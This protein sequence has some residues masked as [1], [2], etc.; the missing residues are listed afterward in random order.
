MYNLKCDE[1]FRKNEA[2]IKGI[3]ENFFTPAKKFLNVED[4]KAII[5]KADFNLNENKVIIW[6]AE[7]LMTRIDT[8]SDL[9]VM[10]QM[11]YVEL[12]CFISRIAHEIYKGSK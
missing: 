6:Y 11:R 2:P 8:L 1:I 5:K 4:C 10:Q 12:L 3:M 9:S 7:S